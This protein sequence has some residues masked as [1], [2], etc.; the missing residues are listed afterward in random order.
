MLIGQDA[1]IQEDKFLEVF[2]LGQVID[3]KENK[4]TINWLQILLRS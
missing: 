2:L 3:I 1:L 4:E